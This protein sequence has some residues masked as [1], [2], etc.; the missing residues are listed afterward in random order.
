MNQ[1]NQSPNV[2]ELIRQWAQERNLIA[3]S[4]SFR[5]LAK[6]SEET[7]E[8]AGGI[9]KQNRAVIAAQNGLD[10]Q[11]CINAAYNEIKDRKGRMI[12]GVFVKKADYEKQ[13]A[14]A[15]AEYQNWLENELGRMQEKGANHG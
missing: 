14:E 10:I 5:Q 9:A 4:D 2:F 8:L 1:R 6:L 7:G 15:V 3:G 11:D 13:A 12:D